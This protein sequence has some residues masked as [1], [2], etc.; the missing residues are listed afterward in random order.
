MG[1]EDQNK[2]KRE[3]QVR[4]PDRSPVPKRG[5]P[6]YSDN[7]FIFQQQRGTKGGA[8]NNVTP[9]KSRP[10][11]DQGRSADGSEL[12]YQESAYLTAM[13]Q[14]KR[15]SGLHGP[16][17]NIIL[18][19]TKLDLVHKDER[20]RKV[21]FEEALALARKLNCSAFI[22]T[23]AKDDKTMG[24]IDG[25]NDCFLICALNCYENSL[26]THMAMGG[27]SNGGPPGKFAFGGGRAMYQS[28]AASQ[29][30]INDAINF[31][32]LYR[33]P[34]SE[35]NGKIE[36][37][38]AEYDTKDTQNNNQNKVKLGKKEEKKKDGCC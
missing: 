38:E 8:G 27:S 5:P 35:F 25:L 22:E 17:Q 10:P 7:G 31:P 4:I 33:P 11:T 37:K 28:E 16:P 30:L 36:R 19:G 32:A 3:S 23:S 24:V 20:Q 15:G 2:A 34:H 1:Q 21:K 6:V 26:R 13:S 14:V 12:E 18:V 9:S 29:F